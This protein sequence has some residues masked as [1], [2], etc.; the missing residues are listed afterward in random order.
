MET[1]CGLVVPLTAT[2]ILLHPLILN[3]GIPFYGDETYYIN[4][5]S[6]YSNPFNL[7]FQWIPASGP[8]PPI[9]TFFSHTVILTPLMYLIGHEAAVKSYILIVAAL[10][11]MLTFLAA[12]I[13]AKEWSLFDNGEGTTL[14]ALVSG[15][16]ML[17]AF[18]NAGLIGAATAPTWSYA[19]LPLSFAFLVRYLRS[20]APRTLLLL[21]VISLFAAANPMWFYVVFIMLV[22]YLPFKLMS[23]KDK[24]LTCMKRYVILIVFLIA[25][26]AFW[27]VPIAAAYILGA[28]GFFQVYTAKNLISFESLSTLSHWNLL[29]TIMVGEHQYDFFWLHPQN[30]GPLNATIPILAAASIITFYRNRYVLFTAVTMIIGIFLT[31]GVSEPG[32]YLYFLLAKNVPYGAGGLLRNP[33]MFSQLTTFSY[34]LLLGLFVAWIYRQIG[35]R[36]IVQKKILR[37]IVVSALIALVLSTITYGA[38][39]DLH[40]YTWPRYAPTTVP[41]AYADI[42]N[43]LL[44]QPGDFKVMW[45]PDGASYVWKPYVI[46]AFQHYISSR[47]DVSFSRVGLETLNFNFGRPLTL[48]GV[49]YVIYHGDSL[50]DPYEKI[51]EKLKTQ[52]SLQTVFSL[53]YVLESELTT[54]LT[55]KGRAIP[56]MIFENREY[57]GPIFGINQ[58][59]VYAPSFNSTVDSEDWHFAALPSLDYRQLSPVEWKLSAKALRPFTL[60]FT[61]PYD[62]LWRVYI[63]GS[64]IQPSNC[65]QVNCFPINRTGE[66]NIRMYYILQDYYVSGLTVSLITII[67]LLSL[68]LRDRFKSREKVTEIVDH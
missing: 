16:F 36:H 13:L 12:R 5:E 37:N 63:D 26:H 3:V 21:G 30:F 58:E 14:F 43:W 61:E 66:L 34:A 33:T 55:E 23:Q 9:L 52:E 25:L 17:L 8:S 4:S 6:F 57:I 39:I 50:D 42:N 11:G 62:K 68:L 67:C 35:Q 40:G 20:G 28:G 48:L 31:K 56:F 65:E 46:T 53:D 1:L 18:T 10:P 2:F 29:D 7:N 24:R 47:P 27:W 64:I 22:I 38:L 49:K 19:T 44:E 60:V 45:V 41:K 54:P 15:L 59:S 32:G 51:L